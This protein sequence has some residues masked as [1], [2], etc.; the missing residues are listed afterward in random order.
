MF[1]YMMMYNKVIQGVIIMGNK[2]TAEVRSSGGNSY[3][4][5]IP[6]AIMK[7]LKLEIGDVLELDADK[8]G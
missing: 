1:I 4:V 5:T 6:P 2:F 7:V 8:V 3:A